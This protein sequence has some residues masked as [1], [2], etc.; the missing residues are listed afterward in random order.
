MRVVELLIE[1]QKCPMK[2]RD[3]IIK[4]VNMFTNSDPNRIPRILAILTE[5]WTKN[6]GMSLCQII[7]NVGM[8]EKTDDPFFVSDELAE[9]HLKDMLQESI[10]AQ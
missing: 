7:G 8:R 3:L 5:Y 10:D 1:L 6:P 4:G 2:T 9:K